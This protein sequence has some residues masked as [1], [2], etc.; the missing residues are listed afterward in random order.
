M[1]IINPPLRGDGH[2][3]YR[4]QIIGNSGTG[5]ST[6]A[7]YLSTKLHIPYTSLD[8]LA[9]KPGWQKT[10]A[11]EFREKVSAFM[12]RDDRCWIVDGNYNQALGT[13]VSDNATDI[14]WLAPP[15][16]YYLPRLIWR[17]LMRLLGLRPSCAEGCK[18]SWRE[19]FSSESIIWFCVTN[20]AVIRTKYKAWLSRM[21]IEAGGKMIRLDESRGE[22]ARW[23]D[24]LE[25]HIRQM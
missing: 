12:M 22:L 4:V 17:T 6:L 10:E 18:E 15:L 9:W 11:D 16:Y 3:N 2:G 14:I 24:D 8:K 20:H 21:S 7:A 1:P 23:K 5:K 19:V 25:W 13:L